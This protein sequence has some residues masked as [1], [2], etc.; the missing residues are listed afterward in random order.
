MNESISYYLGV[1]YDIWSSFDNKARVEE[2]NK[3]IRL[4]SYETLVCEIKNNKAKVFNTYSNTTLRHI[5]EFLKQNNFKAENKK[6][7]ERD[8]M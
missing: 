6:Q 8:Y 4:Y 3:T 7:I 5:K 2:N 1:T